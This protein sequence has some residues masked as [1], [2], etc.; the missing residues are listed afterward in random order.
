MV[1]Q[2]K[3]RLSKVLSFARF[4]FHWGY[5]PFVIY[6]GKIESYIH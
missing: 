5:L 4:I 3:V 1:E 6:L 2:W